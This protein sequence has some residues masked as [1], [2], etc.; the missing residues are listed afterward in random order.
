[1]TDGIIDFHAHAFPDG[2]AERAIKTL[3]EEGGIKARLD[4]TIHS[5]LTSMDRYGIEKSVVCPIATKP[6]QFDP[7][8]R[9]CK[10]IRSD[11]IVPFPSVHPDD[12]EFR[13]RITQIRGEGFKGVKLHPYY[14]EFSL[15]EERLTPFYEGICEENLILVVHTGFDIA[16]PR[17]PMADPERVLGVLR[18][19][20]SMKLVTTHL[21]AWDQWDEVEE[22]LIGREI[23]T[24][25]SFALESLD[26]DL[27]RTLIGNHPARHVFFGSDSPWTDQ[28]ETLSLLREL[29]LGEAR[30]QRI[31]RD[32]ALELLNSV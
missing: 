14:Q 16:F 31:L 18:R 11:R 30:E 29:D 13:E 32:N 3:E 20:P 22:K 2:L 25:I 19:F 12:P 27:A 9:W 28:G 24:E 1:M 5:L 26:R 17:V 4:G 6:S 21:G 7:I 8:F 23:Y 15:D 10:K